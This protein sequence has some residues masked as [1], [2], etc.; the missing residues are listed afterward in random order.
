MKVELQTILTYSMAI[1]L[2][3][4]SPAVAFA[5]TLN[6][7]TSI[8]PYYEFTKNVVGSVADV[9]QFTPPGAS[10][11]NWE[12][13]I[14]EVQELENVDIFVYNGLG[15]EAFVERLVDS[16]DWPNV[17]FVKATD[18]LVLIQ[19]GEFHERIDRIIDTAEEGEITAE[20]AISE[21]EQILRDKRVS[22]ILELFDN[23]DLTKAEAL[24]SVNELMGEYEFATH[25]GDV[26]S[27]IDQIHHKDITHQEGLTAIATAM[28]EHGAD[29]IVTTIHETKELHAHEDENG[30]EDEHGHDEH[31]HEDENGHEDEH[32][33]DE[34][35]HQDE[36]DHAHE[37]FD[38]HVWLDVIL[39]KQQVQNIRDAMIKYDSDNAEI[40]ENNTHSY[41][42]KLDELHREYT[43]VLSNC[44]HDTLVTFHSAFEYLAERYELKSVSVS[45]L[46]HTSDI[47]TADIINLVDFVRDNDVQYVFTESFVDTR[48]LDTIAEE[49]GVG[50]LELSPIENITKEEFENGVTYI[51]KMNENL[52][53]LRTGLSCQ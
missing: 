31:A 38:P 36:H 42:E 37:D 52:D 14:R 28:S 27:I 39:V 6:V 53:A 1:A 34:H 13:S 19:V 23:G 12:P 49:A 51:D 5:D 16:G 35:A 4:V 48:N 9:S 30:H 7:Q 26:G 10:A 44:Q 8:Y 46:T 41:L 11:H 40:Y 43:T 47:S 21:I 32:G 24:F 25:G 18:G 17:T 20:N 15:I 33:H 2:L 29:A 45:G 3:V 22:E 50:I